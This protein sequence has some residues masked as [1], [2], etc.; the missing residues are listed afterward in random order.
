MKIL[1]LDAYGR[2]PHSLTQGNNVDLGSFDQCINIFEHLDSETEIRGKYC[3]GGL[4]IPLID[5]DITKEIVR[6]YLHY[7]LAYMI[8]YQYRL[9]K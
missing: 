5:T 2:I 6:I 9:L 1:V 7:F 8:F 4:V 3:Y